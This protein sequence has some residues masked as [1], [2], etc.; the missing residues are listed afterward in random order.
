MNNGGNAF[1][2]KKLLQGI[3]PVGSYNKQ[4]VNMRG[5]GMTER[6]GQT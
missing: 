5:R 3:T 4:V 2:G 6:E 1:G